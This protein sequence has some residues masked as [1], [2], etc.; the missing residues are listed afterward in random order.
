MSGSRPKVRLLKAEREERAKYGLRLP[1]IL[2]LQ[3]I[4]QNNAT[5]YTSI[6][7]SLLKRRDKFNPAHFS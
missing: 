6:S 7:I 2:F 4:T 1:V 5:R 3:S